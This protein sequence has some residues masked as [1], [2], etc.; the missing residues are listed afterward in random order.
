MLVLN[1]GIF[2]A[3]RAHRR[4]DLAEWRRVMRINLDAN[5]ALL[6]ERHPLLELRAARRAGRGD[7]LE[8]R[9][10]ARARARPPT[11][12]RRPR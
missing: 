3:S 8:E 6:R 5:L 10:R 11:R 9:A 1:A 4:P 12:P 7:R 2:P